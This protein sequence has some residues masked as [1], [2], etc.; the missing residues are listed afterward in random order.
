MNTMRERRIRPKDR[1]HF[2]DIANTPGRRSY[3]KLISAYDNRRAPDRRINNIQVEWI[4][5]LVI[6]S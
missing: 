1:R 2:I 5:E 3:G 4:D 6:C